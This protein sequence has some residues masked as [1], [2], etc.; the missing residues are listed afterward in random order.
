[1]AKKID[2]FGLT[3]DIP[4]N[5]VYSFK[6]DDSQEI[7]F[8]LMYPTMKVILSLP[9][10]INLYV[11]QYVTGESG[12]D[13]LPLPMCNGKSLVITEE[14]VGHYVLIYELQ[15][16]NGNEYSVFE[17]AILSELYGGPMLELITKSNEIVCEFQGNLKNP[18]AVY[19]PQS[20]PT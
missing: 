11:K 3:R 4:G 7:T 10:Q 13:P 6:T 15:E 17:I 12:L 5:T 19:P 1:M 14:Q 2:V 16:K 18:L 20:T 8:N 9:S